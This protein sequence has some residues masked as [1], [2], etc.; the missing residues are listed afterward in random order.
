M[1]VT[2]TR[3]TRPWLSVKHCP[4]QARGRSRSPALVRNPAPPE[5]RPP[6]GGGAIPASEHGDTAPATSLCGSALV[7]GA[8]SVTLSIKGTLNAVQRR[9]DGG[10]GTRRQ[11]SGRGGRWHGAWT[12]PSPASLPEHTSHHGGSP[13][14]PRSSLPCGA[15]DTETQTG[16]CGHATRW[17]TREPRL[18][19]PVITQVCPLWRCVLTAAACSAQRPRT[20]SLGAAPEPLC[21]VCRS[22]ALASPTPNSISLCHLLES[23]PDFSDPRCR[24]KSLNTSSCW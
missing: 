23:L 13:Q 3:I 5:P 18:C 19:A 22:W 11:R 14:T 15:G 1:C 7:A 12:L 20:P 17:D 6:R 10:Q 9:G 16:Q 21:P 4:A 2:Q 8:R 24:H